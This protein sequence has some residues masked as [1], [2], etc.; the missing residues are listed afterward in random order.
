[1]KSI[2]ESKKIDVGIEGAYFMR[3]KKI[4]D[5]RGY[6]AHMMTWPE[7]V[8]IEEVYTSVCA[9]DAVKAW[10]FH[11]LMSLNYCCVVGSIMVGLVDLRG[12]SATFGTRKRIFL[13]TNHNYGVLH[14]PE[15]VWNGYRSM[16]Q[17]GAMLINF[18]SHMHDTDEIERIHP[19]KFPVEF[20]WGEYE[21]AG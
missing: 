16:G 21:V 4:A 6:I 1:M 5:D 15:Q 18:A 3:R 12:D 8:D 19:A 10:H 13:D 17:H 2:D 20:E 11:R 14:I 9:P 7:I